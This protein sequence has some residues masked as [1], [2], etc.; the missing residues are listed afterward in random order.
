M[1]LNV[2]NIFVVV[3]LFSMPVLCGSCGVFNKK[4][5]LVAP[6][7][8][9]PTIVLQTGNTIVNAD[10]AVEIESQK[11]IEI[12]SRA[13]G[14]ISKMYVKEGSKV[15]KGERIAL[16]DP[17]EC[18]QRVNMF[19]AA[20][21]AA[22]A[23]VS[24]AK[25]EVEKLTPLVDKN[26]ISAYQLTAANSNYDAA[27]ASLAQV[28]AQLKDAQIQLSY[29]T[30]TSP[31]SG[32]ISNINVFE[33]TLIS[34]GS[35]I[36]NIAENGDVFA[37]FSFD[38]KKV[39]DIMNNIEGKDIYEKIDNLPLVDLVLADG[40]IYPVKGKLEVA[41]AIINNATGSIT[42]KGVF[43]NPDMIIRAGST[44]KVRIPTQYNDMLLIPQ[45]ATFELQ[46]KK[47]VYLY[48]PKDSTILSKTIVVESQ[49]DKNYIVKPM[50]VKAGDII[51]YEGIEKVRDGFKII[52]QDVISAQ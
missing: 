25:L 31:A 26:I 9:F 27:K 8:A 43:K 22:Y 40:S 19:Q 11:M 35:L 1:R 33:G 15:K 21:T 14:Y 18:Q 3:L 50:D 13:N 34:P 2:R 10:Y 24:N 7:P 38:E 6:V 47:L 28:Q 30:I 52:S 51:L 29:T 23:T 49:D 4:E 46:D 44:G 20:V 36:T 39:L 16:I 5:V 32:I 12:R 42:L 45:K 41:S 17:S 37:Y 48:N